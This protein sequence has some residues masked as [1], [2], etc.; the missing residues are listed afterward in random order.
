MVVYSSRQRAS[1]ER[2]LTL[3][4]GGHTQEEGGC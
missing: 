4:G 2:M 3:G 1:D